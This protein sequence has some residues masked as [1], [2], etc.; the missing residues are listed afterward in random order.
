[1]P[2]EERRRLAPERANPVRLDRLLCLSSTCLFDGVGF[3]D[4][5]WAGI[6]VFAAAALGFVGVRGLLG[7]TV[8]TVVAGF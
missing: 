2:M 5:S 3:I 1:M 4:G 7:A 6:G 8:F